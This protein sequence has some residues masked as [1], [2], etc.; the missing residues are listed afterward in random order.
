MTTPPLFQLFTFPLFRFDFLRNGGKVA[1]LLQ[2]KSQPVLCHEL[3]EHY[4][5]RMTSLQA[6]LAVRQ[7]AD[8]EQHIKVRLDHA[9]AYHRGLS[10]LPEVSLPPLRE[11]GSH[12]YLEFPIRVSERQ[13]LVRYMIEQG[14]DVEEHDYANAADLPCFSDYARD[15]PNARVVAAQV[16]L[17]PTYPGYGR[18]EVE[19]NIATIHSYFRRVANSSRSVAARSH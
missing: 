13:N 2:K 8:V 14:R 18:G 16:V 1:K 10:G 11:D 9:R 15:C 5:R 19:K 17:L 12:I 7:I 4:K 6:R 3:P